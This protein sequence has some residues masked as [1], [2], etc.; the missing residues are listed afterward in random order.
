MSEVQVRVFGVFLHRHALAT[1]APEPSHALGVVAELRGR[2]DV[3]GREGGGGCGA[4]GGGGSSVVSVVGP[5]MGLGLE[6]GPLGATFG[7]ENAGEKLGPSAGAAAQ[8]DGDG[9]EG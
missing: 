2:V 5:V 3:A 9:V 4:G 6:G 8:A 1:G 7:V